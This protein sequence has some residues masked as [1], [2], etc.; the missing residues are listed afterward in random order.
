MF[1]IRLKCLN[2]KIT[3]EVNIPK[4]LDHLAF[5]Y[6]KDNYFPRSINWCDNCESYAVMVL[7]GFK[8][9]NEEE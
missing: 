3:N 6:I 8:E 9:I 2:C 7:Y 4:P 1:K 5:E